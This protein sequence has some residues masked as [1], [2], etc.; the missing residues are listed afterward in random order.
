MV[1]EKTCF[2]ALLINK[3]ISE[4]KFNKSINDYGTNKL[5]EIRNVWDFQKN[6]SEE[7][8]WYQLLEG[9]VKV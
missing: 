6:S 2:L 5:Y 1:S 7:L 4:L 9:L 8:V 3:N